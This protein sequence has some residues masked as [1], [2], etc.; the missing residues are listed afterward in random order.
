M[1]MQQQQRSS[2]NSP[3]DKQSLTPSPL[4][5]IRYKSMTN[6]LTA[7][8]AADSDTLGS[9]QSGGRCSGGSA[10]SAAVRT[11]HH[12]HPLHPSSKQQQQQQ[13]GGGGIYGRQLSTP[14]S[15]HHSGHHQQQQ[16]HGGGGGGGRGL[17]QLHRP[18]SLTDL[19][20]GRSS[21]NDFH[22]SA[23]KSPLKIQLHPTVVADVIPSS[24]SNRRRLLSGANG[25]SSNS[26]NSKHTI[27]YHL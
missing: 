1:I 15:S 24:S 7:T 4:F 23:S 22:R 25:S 18:R 21:G 12:L 13:H 27:F 3:A 17:F 11:R 14:V 8:S 19:L 10:G 26:K 9:S 20:W 6:L 5:N 16:Q 2:T